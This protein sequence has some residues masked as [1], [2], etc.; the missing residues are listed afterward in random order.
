MAKTSGGG[1]GSDI[2]N[3][4]QLATRLYMDPRVSLIMKAL[5]PVMALGYFVLPIDFLPDLVPVLG[6]LDDVAVLL[7]LMR[8]F[9]SLA[10]SSVVSEHRA[11]MAGSPS[12]GAERPAAGSSASTAGQTTADVVDAE[13]RVMKDA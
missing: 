12:Q 6:Q 13:Y 8:L 3:N 4:I 11:A 10:P 7:L 1:I 5:V 2:F 9:I